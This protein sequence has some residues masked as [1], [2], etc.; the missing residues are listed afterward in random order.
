V[1]GLLGGFTRC[2]AGRRDS[3]G[4]GV[5]A[6]GGPV[7]RPPDDDR[8]ARAMLTWLAEAAD[9]L[10]AELLQVLEP[11]GV[12]AAIRSGS[13]P[14]GAADGLTRHGAA[15]LRPALARWDARMAAIPVDAVDRHAADGIRLVCPDDPEWSAQLDDLGTGR[16]YALWVRGTADL[17][18]CCAQSVALIG[19]RAATAYGAH[20]CTEIATGLSRHGRAIVSGGAY[21]IDA[22]A[23][24]GA[25]AAGGVTMAVLAC[26][27]DIA[28]PR[29]HRDL[30]AAIA[31]NG[32]VISEWP[33]GTR[34]ARMRFLL[35][36]RVTAAL[37]SGTVVIEATPRG[38]TLATARHAE[39]LGRPLMAVPGP[40]TSATS[41][42][43][44]A[45]IR[46]GRAACVTSAADVIA[47]IPPFLTG[48]TA[49]RAR[50]DAGSRA[51]PPGAWP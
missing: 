2:W 42:G 1:T 11:A 14:A 48:G 30:L 39:N 37:A 51:D 18:S 36:N 34:P 19:A 47:E 13:L 4:A 10:L 38:G 6:W 43:C 8:V 32:A 50:D 44:H 24:R 5:P 17:R 33:P 29:E 25:L 35:R 3:A 40:V 31:G 7:T 46:E 20:V 15:V 21:G 9:P 23:H 22:C 26:G 49:P 16:P 27:P 45:L 41:E 12:L 28:Y